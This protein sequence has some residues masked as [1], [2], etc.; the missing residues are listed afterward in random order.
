MNCFSTFFLFLY[1]TFI[2]QTE[3]GA[4]LVQ[5]PC[6]TYAEFYRFAFGNSSV[7]AN[8]SFIEFPELKKSI[9]S[10][11]TCFKPCRLEKNYGKYGESPPLLNRWPPW[12]QTGPT[13]DTWNYCVTICS[14]ELW[15]CH[16]WHPRHP[17]WS[18]LEISGLVNLSI[19]SQQIQSF[20]RGRKSTAI[21]GRKCISWA[22]FPNK[23]N[24]AA[25]LMAR[26]I[27][28]EC[29]GSLCCHTTTVLTKSYVDL[30]SD[31]TSDFIFGI[32]QPTQQ[33]TV[34]WIRKQTDQGTK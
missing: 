1:F 20:Y 34:Q 25:F 32:T 13:E 6:W 30:V 31:L 3:I 28:D 23:V 16:P 8:K 14:N 21:S 24:D 10:N 29:P 12:C 26:S 15:D 4:S 5:K 19:S 17:Y 22:K 27:A 33:K 2:C 7:W 18:D 9:N 11:E